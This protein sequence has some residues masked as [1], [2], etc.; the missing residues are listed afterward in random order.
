MIHFFSRRIGDALPAPRYS[1]VF[2]HDFIFGGMEN[3]TATTLTSEPS[4]TRAPLSTTTSRAW[5]RMSWPTNG[6]AICSPAANGPRLLNEGLPLTS[7]TCGASTPAVATRP[8]WS[9]W[10]ISMPTSARPAP[11]SAIFCRQYEEPNR[12][13]R[14]TPIRKGRRVLHMLRHEPGRGQ[15][16]ARLLLYG[17][18]HAR[19]SV[20]TRDLIRA[21]EEASSR[22]L[23]WFFDQWSTARPRGTGGH[24]GRDA[25][26][27]VGTLRLEQK[28]CGS[29]PYRFA[30]R[31]RFEVR[32]KSGRRAST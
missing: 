5:C 17:E 30:A 25:D 15:F 3:T 19:G 8:T 14:S 31:V 21:I 29:L 18:R 13:F 28:Q 1:Q 22:N 11:I 24:L 16:L 4:S 27:K 32:V 26:K 12:S 20:E 10:A 7:N 9:Y 23:D 6:G 2:V